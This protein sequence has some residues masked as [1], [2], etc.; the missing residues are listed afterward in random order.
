M[1]TPADIPDIDAIQTLSMIQLY[2]LCKRFSVEVGKK[3]TD[4]LLREKLI[5]KR[6]RYRN[7]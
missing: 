6:K 2:K 3:D 5:K 4:K 7:K 1:Q